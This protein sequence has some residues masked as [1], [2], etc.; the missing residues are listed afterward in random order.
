MIE[1][2]LE[3]AYESCLDEIDKI[4]NTPD[5]YPRRNGKERSKPII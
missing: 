4:K 3:P 1:Y 5:K 2:N